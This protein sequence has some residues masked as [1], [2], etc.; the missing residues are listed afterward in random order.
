MTHR[1]S[2]IE[3]VSSNEA[4]RLH[5]QHESTLISQILEKISKMDLPEQERVQGYMRHKWRLNHK[6]NSLRNSLKAIELFLTF[7]TRLGKRRLYR[8]YR[9]VRAG[10]P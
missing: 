4:E 6:P 5:D 9:D 10:R 1:T 2:A 3:Q 8:N 7:Y